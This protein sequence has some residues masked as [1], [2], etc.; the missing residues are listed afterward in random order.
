MQKLKI[1]DKILYF[2]VIFMSFFVNLVLPIGKV[3]LP[4]SIV[5]LWSAILLNLIF[6]RNIVIK[7]LKHFVFSGKTNL[8]YMLYFFIYTV[9]L[10]TVFSLIGY[11]GFFRGLTT[12][13]GGIFLQI[14]GGLLFGSFIIYKGF[15]VKRLIKYLYICFYTILVIGLIDFAVCYFKI[16][17]L[18]NAVYMLANER[19][20]YDKGGVLIRHYI[21]NIV[22][23]KSIFVE[24]ADFGYF[25]CLIL[26]FVYGFVTSKYTFFRNFY[27]N[28]FLKITFLPLAVFNLI[29]TQSPIYLIFGFT[30]LIFLSLKQIIKLIVKYNI[31][32]LILMLTAFVMLSIFNVQYDISGTFMN[33][34]LKT[35]G[36]IG[37]LDEFVIAEGSLA[38]RLINYYNTLCVWLKHPFFGVGPGELN[39]Q[40]Y[41]QTLNSSIPLTEE[42]LIKLKRETYT[43]NTTFFYKY[44]AETG[45]TGIMFLY[46]FFYKI[47]KHLSVNIKILIPS[48]YKDFY[49]SIRNFMI[50]YVI[51]TFYSYGYL[52]LYIW[53]LI[54]IAL[55]LCYT[56]KL[57]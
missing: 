22:R 25:I 52:N 33:R 15:S 4:V 13:F 34:I 54:G 21:G 53:V 36:S 27:L 37:N 3:G 19:F 6:K 1:Q 9:I 28:K 49:L 31:I 2:I 24:P 11:I 56:K 7:Y 30:E 12:V 8:K 38:T 16:K 42:I 44:L 43:Y 26:P 47:Y 57:D 39:N 46:Y 48:V 51:L 45:I 50:V 41:I 17:P 10:L 55:G 29:L 35:F 20:F 14:F 32:L 18:M 40:I 5:L 23:V